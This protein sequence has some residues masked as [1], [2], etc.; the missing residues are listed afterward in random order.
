MMRYF[1]H[2]RFGERILPDHEGVEL[3]SRSAARGE[4]MAVLRDLSDRT[5]AAGRTRWASWFLQVADADGEFL[6]LPIGYPALDLVAPHG[7]HG[8]RQNQA[9]PPDAGG[10]A[11]E[12]NRAAG[13]A[14]ALARQM[15]AHNDRTAEL[16]ER[17]QQLRQALAS[18]ALVS[19][20]AR[21][22][23][24]ELLACAQF[25][26][27]QMNDPTSCNIATRLRLGARPHLVVLPDGR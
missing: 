9:Q 22:H 21:L 10:D 16:L 6:R 23:A 26:S 7:D 15:L 8:L 24:R 5:T 4:A 18:E 2:L 11:E 3:P 12:G 14:A 17:N 19:E 25:V 27:T 13:T 20:M 1:F